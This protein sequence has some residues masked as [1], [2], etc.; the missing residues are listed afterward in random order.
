MT[1][2]LVAA[3]R[4]AYSPTRPDRTRE[5]SVPHAPSIYS[6]RTLVNSD[7]V[8][9]ISL[10]DVLHIRQ[11][12]YGQAVRSF[13]FGR[14]ELDVLELA[15]E[16]A[17][18]VGASPLRLVGHVLLRNGMTFEIGAAKNVVAIRLRTS[19]GEPSRRS[20]RIEGCEELEALKRA[21]LDFKRIPA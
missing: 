6:T 11:L 10:T 18:K 5:R 20:V 2:P 16:I 19:S 21:I 4:R 13:R 15:I 17:E 3:E 9:Q 14:G 7:D 12:R 1:F 8:Q